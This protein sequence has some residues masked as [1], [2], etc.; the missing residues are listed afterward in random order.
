MIRTRRSSVVDDL[1]LPPRRPRHPEVRLTR[2]ERDLYD[3]TTEFLRQLYR[4]GFIQPAVQEEADDE[5]PRRRPTGQG[6]LQLAL[7]HLRQRLCSSARALAESLA[8][9]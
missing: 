1:D 6:T 4:E 2:A 5:T 9:V 3:R 8:H 7:I